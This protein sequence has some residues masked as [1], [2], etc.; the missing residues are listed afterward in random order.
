ML[1]TSKK[2]IR[3][4]SDSFQSSLSA[5]LSPFEEYEYKSL[6]AVVETYQ[7]LEIKYD[8]VFYDKQ[9]FHT[10][11]RKRDLSKKEKAMIENYL[12]SHSVTLCTHTSS[13][14]IEDPYE[15]LLL[16]SLNAIAVI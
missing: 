14:I 5:L 16:E 6:Y 4:D 7:P 8:E 10:Y 13:S 3:I 12:S 2:Y 1:S 15:S 11:L 9:S